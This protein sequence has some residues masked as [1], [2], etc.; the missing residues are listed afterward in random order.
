MIKKQD[1]EKVAYRI[2]AHL[3]ENNIPPPNYMW[4]KLSQV[5]T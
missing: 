4:H 3:I 1:L 5:E 2:D